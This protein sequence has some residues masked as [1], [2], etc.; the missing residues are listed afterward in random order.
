M[1]MVKLMDLG[2][3]MARMFERSEFRPKLLGKYLVRWDVNG[4]GL[5]D[6]SLGMS[7]TRKEMLG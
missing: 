7:S 1:K 5:E 3:F 6:E 2:S 4:C